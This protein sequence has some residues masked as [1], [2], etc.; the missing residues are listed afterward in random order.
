MEI[1]ICV[2]ALLPANFSTHVFF[3]FAAVCKSYLHSSKNSRPSP[4]SRRATSTR[5][6]WLKTV[7]ELKWRRTGV[8]STPWPTARLEGT[9]RSCALWKYLKVWTINQTQ[10]NDNNKMLVVL[11]TIHGA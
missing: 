8:L 11:C 4:L 9:R 2:V 5:P 3:F 6:R 1:V 7:L 10:S